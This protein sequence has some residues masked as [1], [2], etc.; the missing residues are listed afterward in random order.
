MNGAVMRILVSGTG[1]QLVRSMMER[2]NLSKDIEICTLGRPA[3]DL[4]RPDF[5]TKSMADEKFDIVV[6]AAAYTAVDAAE[7]EPELALA[8]NGAGAGAIA[9]VAAE[10]GV[11]II[12]IST[13]YVFNGH[14]TGSWLETDPTDP[15]S[16]YGKS[17]LAGERAVLAATPK[18][19]VVRT[20]WVYS[21][22]GKNF[23]K[24][25]L[26]LAESQDEVS[27]VADQFGVPTSALDIADGVLTMARNLVNQQ[28]DPSLYGVFHM[29]A[30]AND[31][32]PSWANFAE[33]IFQASVAAGGPFAK[34]RQITTAQ[35]PTPAAR[36][37]NSQLNCD[38]LH[39]VHGIRLPVWACP[40]PTVI[41][42]I[43]AEA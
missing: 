32:A 28:D 22:F 8:I 4:S 37:E 40:I 26:R 39:S 43:L 20:S 11:P 5:I 6:N 13:D 18:S 42:R 1:G 34:V 3:L 7:N 31:T 24:T 19:A 38:K 21:P 12:Q 10:R 25:M 41:G 29:T 33:Q 14:K 27:V 23:A 2:A 36:P 17:K 9:K 35:Y 16:V 30:A 15:L